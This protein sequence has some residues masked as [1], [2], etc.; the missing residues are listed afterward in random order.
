LRKISIPDSVTYMGSLV[1]D[2][3]NKL[4]I[5]CEID[6]KPL[7]W[8]KD[9]FGNIDNKIFWGVLSKEKL[10]AKKAKEEAERKTKEA[11]EKAKAK[12]ISDNFEVDGK[13][14]KKYIGKGGEVVIPDDF[15]TI[16]PKA[17]YGCKS[18]TS[19]VIPSSITSIGDSAFLG[20][21]GLKSVTIS[22]G[23]KTIGN[24]AFSSC[25]SIENIAIP[26]SVTTIGNE[27]FSCC[28]NIESVTIPQSIAS[29]GRAAFTGCGNLKRVTIP[30]FH[31]LLG[32][33]AF[34]D[35]CTI[36]LNGI[37]EE[38]S[39][40]KAKEIAESKAREEA[41]KIKAQYI[42]DNFV[43]EG[44]VLKKYIGKGGDVVI[45]DGI[46]A[47]GERAFYDC[48]N[49]TSITVP[50]SVVEF[51]KSAFYIHTYRSSDISKT[52]KDF[53]YKGTI[54]N[55]CKIKYGDIFSQPAQYAKN[56]YI[57]D[58]IVRDAII[59][60]GVTSISDFAFMNCTSLTSIII[61]NSVRIIGDS[62]FNQCGFLK[63]VTMG[64]GINSIGDYAFNRCIHLS[65]ITIPSHVT[66][67][68]GYAF[69]NCNDLSS[70]TIPNSVTA[71]GY[72]LCWG[73][74]GITIYC[75]AKK[76]SKNWHKNWDV[77]KNKN[78]LFDK[79][80]CKVV[81]GYKK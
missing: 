45:P 1:F 19:I 20:C 17:F 66:S 10:L 40:D 64:N 50:E 15:N 28:T 11:A 26:K 48:E 59:P 37:E 62:A 81:W 77:Y 68:G 39:V 65:N 60:D 42:R 34:N 21:K 5:N 29:I 23:L 52:L 36:L 9:W 63:S 3:C 25:I 56:F 80:R 49:V 51:E 33:K 53:Y 31:I 57:C 70:I 73:C 54:E 75:E 16:A 22:D 78:G 43:I 12:Y 74:Y 79:N 47:V 27:A 61:P 4:T 32:E 46:E 38:L 6:R 69:K 24:N 41:E 2:G 58:E 18:L 8:E 76:P 35:G 72:S 44:K 13:V 7:G 30:D 14:L 67:I 55:W 71:I